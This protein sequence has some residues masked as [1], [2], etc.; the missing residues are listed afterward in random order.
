[1]ENFKNR[2]KISIKTD[3]RNYKTKREMFNNLEEIF[4]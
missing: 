1:M 2:F 3:E 4:I